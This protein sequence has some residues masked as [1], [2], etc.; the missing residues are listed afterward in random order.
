MPDLIPK[1]KVGPGHKRQGKPNRANLAS[2]QPSGLSRA[3]RIAVAEDH[4][5]LRE[6]IIKLIETDCDSYEL[7]AEFASTDEAARRCGDVRA[8]I[9]VIG[10]NIVLS[11]GAPALTRLRQLLPGLRILLYSASGSDEEIVKALQQGVDGFIG[12]ANSSSEFL[13]AL[14]RL[15]HGDSY[16]CG[17]SSRL[18]SE[19]ASGKHSKKAGGSHLSPR[20]K[21]ILQH[22]AGGHTSKEIA[23]CLDLSVATVDTHRRN[24]M[25]KIGARNVADLIRYG[26]KHGLLAR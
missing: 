6:L 9:L 5:L 12:K 21:E 26:H 18:L 22:I 2:G 7:V 13:Y 11:A 17:Q 1:R 3:C 10:L 15:S 4:T 23:G 8:E 25:L 19:I 20:E 14:D 16:F 24:A